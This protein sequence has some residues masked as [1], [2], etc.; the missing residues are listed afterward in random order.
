M[1]TGPQKYPN[2]SLA[3]FYQS[4]LGGDAMEVNAIVWHTTEGTSL[5]SYDGGTQAPTLTAVPDFRAHKLKWFQH[6]DFDVSARALVNRSGGV[7]TNTL[8]VAQVELVSTCDPVTHARWTRQGVQHLFAP[9]V[10]DW[11]IRD[12]AAFAKWANEKHD[13]PLSSGL[14]FK[15]YPASY[16]AS[17]VRMSPSRWLAFKGHCGHQHVPENDHGDP[18]NFPMAAILAAAKA[19]TT[20]TVR[21][22]E[23]LSSIGALVGVP[24][25]DIA[26]AN[27]ISTPYRIYPGQ[28]LTIPKRQS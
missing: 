11:V 1:K 10:P 9:E 24:W 15:A 19:P 21:P 14:T 3:Y 17:S 7:Q 28:V 26:R 5:P 20:H 22:G 27:H 23:T 4:R 25:L 12:L 6:F 16:G 13:V 18:G 2:A 8:N